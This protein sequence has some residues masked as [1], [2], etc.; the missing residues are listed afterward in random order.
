[1]GVPHGRHRGRRLP[2]GLRLGTGPAAGGSP[3]ARRLP[4][5]Q[6]RRVPGS[7]APRRHPGRRDRFPSAEPRHLLRPLR[8]RILAD[9]APGARL[10]RPGPG[11]RGRRGPPAL[12]AGRIP[13]PGLDRGSPPGQLRLPH[14]RL[15][16]GSLPDAEAERQRLPAH[17]LPAAPRHA[18]GDPAAQAS[19]R[20]RIRRLAQRPGDPAEQ[21]PLSPGLGLQRDQVPPGRRRPGSRRLPPLQRGGRTAAA[22]LKRTG[23]PGTQPD[24][25]GLGLPLRGGAPGRLAR[26]GGSGQLPPPAH[27]G[28][29]ERGGTAGSPSGPALLPAGRALLRIPLPGAVAPPRRSRG[30]L[31]PPDPGREPSHRAVGG[32]PRRH[33]DP[34]VGPRQRPDLRSRRALQPPGRGDLPSDPPGPGGLPLRAAAGGAGELPG[35]TPPPEPVPAGSDGGPGSGA[36]RPG[37]ASGTARHPGPGGTQG[38]GLQHRGPPQALPL[39]RGP[40]PVGRGPGHR[41]AGASPGGRLGAL[42]ALQL[43]SH[44]DAQPPGLRAEPPGGPLR[45][46]HPL[47]RGV[48][49]HR[50]RA[51]E[52]RRLPRSLRP[53]REDRPGRGPGAPLPPLPGAR[54]DAPGVGRLHGEDRPG[55]PRRHGLPGRRADPALRLSQGDRDR[56]AGAGSPEAVPAQLLRRHGL[57]P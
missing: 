45:L 25:I 3:P 28:Q 56:G 49:Q 26:R 53:D 36:R 2:R 4:A 34:G 44:P 17:P 52:R 1:M 51:G 29:A 5:Q 48:P 47:R 13:A 57:G 54:P 43:R 15:R 30:R 19:L 11:P 21:R 18:S 37:L 12:A 31:D 35:R 33:P 7:D 39:D 41:P 40:G 10:A 9:P 14:R 6:R 23:G 20:G 32:V 38:A 50:R 42:G 22:R 46:A 27:S 8:P 24:R 55:R 16:A